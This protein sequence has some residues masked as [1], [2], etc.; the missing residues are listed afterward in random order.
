MQNTKSVPPI[1]YLISALIAFSMAYLFTYV[2]A[3]LFIKWLVP[4]PELEDATVYTGRLE[5]VGKM[6]RSR[7]FNREKPPTYYIVD[8]RGRHEIYWGLPGDRSAYLDHRHNGAIGTV[9]HHKIFGV[10]QGKFSKAINHATAAIYKSDYGT[11]GGSRETF[12]RYFNYDRYTVWPTIIFGTGFVY[13]LMKY[14]TVKRES[15]QGEN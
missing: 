11:A 9:W 2:N 5:V 1:G 3:P 15:T 4:F 8:E 12:E 7:K 6:G 10:I 14:S 13:Y